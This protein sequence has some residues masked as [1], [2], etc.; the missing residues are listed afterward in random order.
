MEASK[1][2]SNESS[3][4]NGNLGFSFSLIP[5]LVSYILNFGRGG[6][7]RATGRVKRDSSVDYTARYICLSRI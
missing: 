5:Y 1:Q 4:A 6:K 2:A 3:T 7:S